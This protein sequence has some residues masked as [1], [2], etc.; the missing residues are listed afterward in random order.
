MEMVLCWQEIRFAWRELPFRKLVRNGLRLDCIGKR[1]ERF[2]FV[3]LNSA[4]TLSLVIDKEFPAQLHEN[5]MQFCIHNLFY[6]VQHR[7]R[8]FP[9][10][11]FL[12]IRLQF[13]H[14]RINQQWQSSDSLH[15]QHQKRV[16]IQTT[17]D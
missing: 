9:V 4:K 7:Q 5:S 16:K 2:Y 8:H 17:T 15:R 14:D 10:V 13:C 6:L 12:I 11:K 1:S 3:K